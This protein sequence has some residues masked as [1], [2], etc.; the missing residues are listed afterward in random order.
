[1]PC[2]AGLSS[3]APFV[4]APFAVG[5]RRLP[6]RRCLHS[7]YCIAPQVLQRSDQGLQKPRNTNMPAILFTSAHLFIFLNILLV[8]HVDES[9][10]SKA[11]SHVCLCAPVCLSTQQNQNSF[12]YYHQ[13][14]HR[15]S[16]SRVPATHFIFGQ[17]SRSQGHKV[18]KHISGDRVAGA[19]LHSD[20]CTA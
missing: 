12:N 4:T 20:K 16:P 11:F 13:T 18:Q 1:M 9:Q 17:R 6:T 5:R 7:V 8:T 19:S 2:A 3:S 10:R 15:D 14:C